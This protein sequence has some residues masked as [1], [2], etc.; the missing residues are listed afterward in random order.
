LSRERE[1][2]LKE[3]SGSPDGR[4]YCKSHKKGVPVSCRT[5]SRRNTFSVEEESNPESLYPLP[6][7][8]L[9]NLLM[10]LPS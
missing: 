3:E 1:S 7:V 10:R 4:D 9:R 6:L 8:S 5:V 2:S